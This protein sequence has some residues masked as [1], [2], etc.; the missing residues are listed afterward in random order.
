MN[1]TGCM[2][3]LL[4]VLAILAVEFLVVAGLLSVACWAFG[5]VFTWKLAVGV[6]MVMILAT[7]V[8]GKGRQGRG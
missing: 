7:L 6:W 1:K 8:I 2:A 3:T 4:I 5:W